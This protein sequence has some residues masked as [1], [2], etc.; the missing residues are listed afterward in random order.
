MAKLTQGTIL[1]FIG[2]DGTSLKSVAAVEISGISAQRDSI[3]TTTLADP[4][5]TF[6]SGLMSPG[7]AQFKIQFDPA[8]TVHTDLHTAYKNGTTLKW[9]L[10]WSDGT[11]APTVATQNFTLPTTR[12]FLSFSGFIQDVTFDFS[13]NNVVNSQVSLQISGMPNFSAKV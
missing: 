10:G 8:N 13:I 12:T 7:S 5:K 1:Y 3:E 9:A 11:A 4:A 6:M 2:E